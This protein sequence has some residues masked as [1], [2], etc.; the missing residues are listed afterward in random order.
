M[1]KLFYYFGTMNSSKTAN[2]LMNIHNYRSQGKKVLLM[3]PAID[4]RFGEITVRSR[5]GIEINADFL[6]ERNSNLIDFFDT[7]DY[8]ET[9][10]AIFIDE[11]QFLSKTNI[12][13]LREISTKIN[14]FC[15]GLRTDY[16][17]KL[18]EGSKR[19]F[20]LADNI[21]EIESICSECN[22]KAIINAK[23]VMNDNKKVIIYQGSSDIDLGTE[24]KY[25]PLCYCC[26]SHKI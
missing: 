2:L 14:I 21:Q 19:L 15:F 25:Q 23:F 5:I 26:W 9:I 22:N 17:G 11:V 4:D 10:D 7:S 3:K 24:D 6:I 1:T 16:L 13:Q 8:Y 20:E 18:F 12:E